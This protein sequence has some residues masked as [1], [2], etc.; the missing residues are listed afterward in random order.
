MTYSEAQPCISTPTLETLLSP[1]LCLSEEKFSL[2]KMAPSVLWMELTDELGEELDIRNSASSVCPPP[3][4]E[5]L[6]CIVGTG[7]W[8]REAG[9]VQPANGSESNSDPCWGS[10]LRSPLLLYTY[11]IPSTPLPSLSVLQNSGGR[12]II[13]WPLKPPLTQY[14]V[15]LL[16]GS[17]PY[18]MRQWSYSFP[19]SPP[20]RGPSE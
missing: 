6:L 20:C 17:S 9:A 3:S 4:G 14:R 19:A 13:Y 18:P 11:A 16:M 5:G 7:C 12:S 15:W 1:L 2:N 10:R 8:A